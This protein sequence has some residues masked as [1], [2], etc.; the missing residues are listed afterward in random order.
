MATIHHPNES[1]T[2]DALWNLISQQPENVRRVL[3][4][5]LTSSFVNTIS[6]Q[7]ENTIST[8]ENNI[9]SKRIN[10]LRSLCGRNISKEDLQSDERL[11][12]LLNK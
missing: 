1:S 7:N 11:S 12:Y 5:R 9:Y 6:T 2:I 3:A 4:E 8:D 10:R